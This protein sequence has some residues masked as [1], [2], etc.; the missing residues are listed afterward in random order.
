MRLRQVP[1]S[2]RRA[3]LLAAVLL[4][5]FGSWAPSA[6]TEP[7]DFVVVVNP[8]N[9][10]NE[11]DAQDVSRMFLRQLTSW[12]D[13]LPVSPV[14]L[15]ATSP[16][17]ERFSRAVHRRPTAGVMSYWDRQIFAG[18]GVPP[19]T[20]ASEGDLLAFVRTHPGAIGYASSDAALREGVK[21]I[22][23]VN[24]KS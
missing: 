13:G 9:P 5:A 19:P 8:A 20:R 12:P 1:A 7:P 17:R 14:D 22:R 23:L 24:G 10:A 6:P 2:R 4:I 16:L 11:L 15:S 3:R 18:R 21:V